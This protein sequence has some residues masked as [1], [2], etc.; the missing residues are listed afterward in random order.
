MLEGADRMLREKKVG[1]C[2]IS[3]HNDDLHAQCIRRLSEKGYRIVA[4][5]SP[6]HSY[7]FDGL[8]VAKSA[9]FPGPEE[10]QI[11]QKPA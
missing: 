1:Y 6:T 11:S 2:F 8:V 4:D 10:I 9:D 3:T 5:A 7:S